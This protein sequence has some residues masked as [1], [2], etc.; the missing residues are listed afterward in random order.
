MIIFYGNQS[1]L[2]LKALNASNLY[3]FFNIP[4]CHYTNITDLPKNNDVIIIPLLEKH[5]IELHNYN[6]KSILNYHN[7][8]LFMNK[9]SFYDYAVEN[10]LTQFVPITNTKIPNGKYIVKPFSENSGRK[11]FITTNIDNVSLD[12]F[13]FQQ[14]LC[15]QYEYTTHIVANK[16]II[17]T[18]ITYR[19]ERNRQIR[20]NV[21]NNIIFTKIEIEEDHLNILQ[22]FLIPCQYTGVC[23]I[24]YLIIDNKIIVF[25]CNPRLGGSLMI[26]LNRKDL[27][28]ILV[29]LIT[30]N[31]T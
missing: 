1:S 28:T 7:T 26:S 3:Q 17:I 13:L 31:T 11:M 8:I 4:I 6:I 9:K 10:N 5:N 23:N 24:D 19:F 18:S 21:T 30:T 25:E 20:N 15:T 12:T 29:S 2:W 14:Y 27:V 16:G 22:Q